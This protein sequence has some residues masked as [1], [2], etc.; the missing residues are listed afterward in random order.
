M[1]TIGNL[2]PKFRSALKCIFLFAVAKAGDIRKYTP[3]AILSP[4]VSDINGLASTGITVTCTTGCTQTFKGTLLAFLADN[5][6][7]HA[8][9]GFKESFSMSYTF[10]R[11]CLAT[12]TQA[13]SHF[14]SHLFS[15]RTPHSHKRHCELLAGPLS[16]HHSSTYGVNRK[17]ILEDI[18]NFSVV[19]N[20][21]HDVMHDLLEGIVHDELSHLLNHCLISKYFK[22]DNLNDR[23]LS[24]DYGYSESSNKP[25]IIDS[26]SAFVVRLRQSASQM[27]L[28]SRTMPLLIGHF[29]PADSKAWQCFGWLLSILDICTSHTCDADTV[30]YLITLIEEHHVMFKEAYPRRIPMHLL[31]LK[32]SALS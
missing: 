10:C 11:S 12:H 29:V 8:I 30:A 13:S 22:L 26:A 28:L 3:D 1:F 19:S 21:P 25:A 20:L 9:G 15:Q 5:L 16:S 23:I 24:F 7:S 4:F 32:C 27:W 2:H 31:Y 17:S 14:V 6:A 18:S